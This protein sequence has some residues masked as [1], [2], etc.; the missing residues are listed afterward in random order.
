[1]KHEKLL[2]EEYDLLKKGTETT[3]KLLEW[4]EQR[5]TS[6]EKRR[7]MLEKGMVALDSAVHEQKLNFVRAQ[8]TELNRRMTALISTSERGF[9]THENMQIRNPI[10]PHPTIVLNGSTGSRSTSD[11]SLT[12]PA[13]I[14]PTTT[15]QW[16]HK[17]NQRLT[18]ELE[19]KTHLIDQLQRERR[20]QELR[21]GQISNGSAPTTRKIYGNP[22]RPAAFVRP[23]PHQN[24]LIHVMPQP[25]VKVHDTLL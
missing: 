10:A 22:Q 13:G 1:A 12:P 15:A 24:D 3:Q 25:P 9:P 19:A 23:A 5:L 20:L 2:N 21:S 6:L 4:Y 16:L 17:Q 8:I 18:E 11:G 14:S 7:Q